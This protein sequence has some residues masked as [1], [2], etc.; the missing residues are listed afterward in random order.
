MFILMGISSVYTD[1]LGWADGS[2]P[3]K[4]QIMLYSPEIV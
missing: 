1:F 2:V 4:Y 3:K